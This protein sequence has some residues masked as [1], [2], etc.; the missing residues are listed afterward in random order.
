VKFLSPIVTGGFPAPGP[1]A[2]VVDVPVDVFVLELLDEPQA[3]TAIANATATAAVLN[4]L[5]VVLVLNAILMV[6]PRG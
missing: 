2:P 5:V 1:V 3:A 6:P 4:V